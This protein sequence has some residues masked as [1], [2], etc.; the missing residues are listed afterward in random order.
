MPK[1]NTDTL[2]TPDEL[3]DPRSYPDF[4]EWMDDKV[5]AF[6]ASDTTRATARLASGPHKTFRDEVF[7]FRVFGDQVLA[8]IDATVIFPADNGPCDVIVT[9]FPNR[10]DEQCIQIVKAVDGHDDRLRME[11]LSRSG[12]SP[13][14]GP[15]EKAGQK[16]KTDYEIKATLEAQSQT[17]IVAGQCR[18]VS[19]A[20]SLKREKVYPAGT[21][22]IVAFDDRLIYENED[23]CQIARVASDAANGCSFHQAYLVGN[24]DKTY[25]QLIWEAGDG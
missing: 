21:W 12:H 5:E 14:S 9:D 4:V 2:L 17:E 15:I 3:R 6:R 16:K 22:L 20:I 13:G 8:G 25:C 23:Y 7:A 18:L 10:G 24:L 1:S 11:L 19:D